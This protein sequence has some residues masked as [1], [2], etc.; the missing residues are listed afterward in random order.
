MKTRCTFHYEE[1]LTEAVSASKPSKSAK[2]QRVSKTKSTSKPAPKATHIKP[3]PAKG[4][5][6]D[7]DDEE[8]EDESGLENE[9]EKE[10]ALNELAEQSHDP[11]GNTD[12]NVTLSEILFK[13]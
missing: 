11:N 2:V 5:E 4:L 8:E 7:N 13:S 12:E 1:S 10:N 3:V 9:L 6:L